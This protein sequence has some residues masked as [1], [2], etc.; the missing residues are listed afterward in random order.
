[1][2]RCVLRRNR[3]HVHRRLMRSRERAQFERFVFVY[4]SL[5][6]RR[7]EDGWHATSDD[8]ERGPV[9]FVDPVGQWRRACPIV[10]TGAAGR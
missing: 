7:L 4:V 2:R 1:M 5:S 6:P 3:D 10:G 8:S 9:R